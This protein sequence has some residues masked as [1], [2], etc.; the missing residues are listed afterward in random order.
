M[1]SKMNFRFALFPLLLTLLGCAQQPAKQPVAVPV[2]P[3][4]AAEAKPVAL[5]AKP[6]VELPKLNLTAQMLYQFLASEIAAQRGQ[7][8][9]AV[10][11]ILDL[12][13]STR[14]PRL[15]RRA[16]ELALQARMEG[17][18]L[19]AAR[20][21]LI[22]DPSEVRA[23]QTITAL[24]VGG[25][26]LGEAKV[27]LERLLADEGN[28]VGSA[29][30]SLHQV[31]VRQANKAAVL[32]LVDELS[33][34]YPQLP[35]A[36]FALA[37]AAWAAERD[38]QALREIA[39]VLRLRP[40]WEMAALF[41]GQILQ[42]TSAA[43]ALDFFKD[44]LESYPKALDIRL[45]YARLLV[46]EKRY[47]DARIQFE[48]LLANFPGNA[49][50]SV[51]LGLLSLQLH[52]FD[53]AEL[54][55]KQALVEKY[56]DPNAVRMYLGQLEE[57]RQRYREAAAWY[58]SV[59]PGEHQLVA[60][61]KYAAMLAKLNRT[62]DALQYLRQ[63]NVQSNQ[64][65][66]QVIIAEA[67]ILRAA[68]AYQEAYDLL[69]KALEKLPNYPDLLYDRAM[70][71]EK[72]GR[73]DTLEQDLRKLIQIKPDYA[74]AYNALGYTLAVRG[75]RLDEAA[76]LIE[77]ALQLTPDDPFIM[78][79]M[80]WVYFRQGAADKALPLLRRA[81]AERP[82]PE[83][84]AHLGE[85]LWSQGSREEADKLWQS[86]LKENPDN[87]VL[88]DVIKRFKPQ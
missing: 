35:E 88:L 31:L 38:E 27:H 19:E 3:V 47:G 14:D 39:E 6:A 66:V 9:L 10:G 11:G 2:A 80:G 78:D 70:V 64:Q 62:P 7:P 29:F 20:L 24:L 51:A 13:K 67:Q 17:P 48:K 53:K 5:P 23:R 46:A 25:G 73:L 8:A 72:V 43:Q 1:P 22:L 61:L 79:S 15:A 26:H 68:K 45:T 63:I 54:Y 50:V 71:A 69:T 75:E 59:T 34:P 18:A 83:I 76:Q 12:A 32:A 85:V 41:Q 37:Q 82:D 57:E 49:E 16:T 21:W 87:E 28:N 74:H 65:R 33:K 86:S 40:D 77:K 30:L 56:R 52:D 81:Y 36:H 55:L 60:Q 42:R 84:A 58:V 4:V 44:Y